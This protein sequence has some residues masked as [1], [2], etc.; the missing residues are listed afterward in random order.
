MNFDSILRNN[1]LNELFMAEY[2]EI[3]EVIKGYKAFVLKENLEDFE[4]E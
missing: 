3:A 1:M 4:N 2:D